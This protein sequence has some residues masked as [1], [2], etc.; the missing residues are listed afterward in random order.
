[1]RRPPLAAAALLAALALAGCRSTATE[2][3]RW[4]AADAEVLT[5]H[6]D[7]PSFDQGFAVEASGLA[8]SG[9]FLYVALEKYARVLQLPA[10][11]PA[12]ARAIAIAVPAHSELEGVAFGG[13]ALYLCDEAHAAVYEVP[14]PAGEELVNFSAG[15]PLPATE[16]EL[17]GPDIEPGKVGVEGIA[18]DAA[19]NRWWLLLERRGSPESGC[20]STVFPMRRVGDT[21]EEAGAPLEIALEDCDWRLSALELWRGELLALKT[22]FPGERYELIAIDPATGSTRPVLELTD[23]L[24]SVRRD[25]Y[26]NNVEGIAVTADGALFVVSDN[27]WTQVVDDPEPPAAA[28][29][30][31][32]LRIPPSRR[33]R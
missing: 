5:W 21:L 26:S 6:A 7:H 3:P 14:L 24:R 9:R 4:D 1:M 32:L 17:V 23:L 13:G 12:S 10:S 16:L 18:V 30:T 31:L 20:V 33:S 27:A 28:E 2:R 15:S 8:A 29:R 11:D 25:G 19:A 22:Q